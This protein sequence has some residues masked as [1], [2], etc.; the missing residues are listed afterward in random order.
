[1]IWNVLLSSERETDLSHEIG[2]VNFTICI[3]LYRASTEIDFYNKKMTLSYF[4]DDG[5]LN[6]IPPYVL[7]SL[8][9]IR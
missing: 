7:S 9:Y 2:I 4:L 5:V 1:M 3:E 6:N 8:S